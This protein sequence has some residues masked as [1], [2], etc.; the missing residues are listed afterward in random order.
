MP[1]LDTVEKVA[2]ALGLSPGFLAYGLDGEG[3]PIESLRGGGV[4]GRLQAVRQSQQLSMRALARAA[5]LTEAS[6]RATESGQTIPTIATVEALAVALGIS[7]AWL[8]Y[9]IGP[10]VLASRRRA[11]ASAP[12]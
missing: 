2:Y 3:A 7:P 4:G 11:S 1:R 6:V 9:G 10:Q 5:A 12:L 8:A